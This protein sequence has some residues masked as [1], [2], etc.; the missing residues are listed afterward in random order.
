MANN[1]PQDQHPDRPGFE[2]VR[3]RVIRPAWPSGPGPAAR[4]RRSAR[5]DALF[6]RDNPPQ[7]HVILDEAV[8]RRQVGGPPCPGSGN[9]ARA[10]R[11]D[12]GRAGGRAHPGRAGRGV[13]RFSRCWRIGLSVRSGKRPGQPEPWH[14]ARAE[15]G[16]RGDAVA[17]GGDDEQPVGPVAALPGPGGRLVRGRWP[18]GLPG[19]V[20][21]WC[22]AGARACCCLRPPGGCRP[23]LV[24]A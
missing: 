13:R 10:C 5:Q 20:R 15:A 14:H 3:M 24:L 6:S 9:R 22:P 4:T 16:D 1:Q 17:G 18:A 7:I 11:S 21:P 8:L 19:G 2:A 12:R 23:W